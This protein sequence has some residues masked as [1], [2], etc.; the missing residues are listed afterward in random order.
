MKPTWIFYCLSAQFSCKEEKGEGL[1][2]MAPEA[3]V[4]KEDREERPSLGVKVL[5]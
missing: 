4:E 1:V 5:L 3:I 2:L